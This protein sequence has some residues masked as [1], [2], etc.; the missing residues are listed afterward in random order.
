MRFKYNIWASDLAKMEP[1]L[2]FVAV[3]IIIGYDRYFH[4]ICLT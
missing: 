1:Y 2:L 3:L 4:Q